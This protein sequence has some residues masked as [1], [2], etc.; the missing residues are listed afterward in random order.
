[1][2]SR[3]KKTFCGVPCSMSVFSRARLL[4]LL[5]SIAISPFKFVFAPPVYL[6]DIVGIYFA[7]VVV[8]RGNLSVLFFPFRVLPPLTL[9]SPTPPAFRSFGFPS[10]A[11]L[12]RPLDD[13]YEPGVRSRSECIVNWCCVLVFLAHLLGRPPSVLEFSE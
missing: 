9:N 7:S 4:F 5:K 3:L 10:A 6:P 12:Y 13:I 1:M 8:T 11:S 2:I